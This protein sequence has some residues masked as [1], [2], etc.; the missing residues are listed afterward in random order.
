M[1]RLVT[2]EI[3][4]S[5]LEEIDQ[6]YQGERDRK[7]LILLVAD[8]TEEAISLYCYHIWQK[9]TV[10][11]LNNHHKVEIVSDMIC[12][13]MPDEIYLGED[14]FVKN[15]DHLRNVFSAF[16]EYI[17]KSGYHHYMRYI[18]KNSV[19]DELHPEVALL[20]PTSGSLGGRKTAALSYA[21]LRSNAVSIVRALG[22]QSGERA[23]LMLPISYVYGLS[24]VNSYLLSGGG[25][26]LPPGNMFQK[27]Y[28][29]FLEQNRVNSFCGVPHTYEIMDRLKLFRR[30]WKELHLVTQAGGAMNRSLKEKMLAWIKD[31]KRRG[32]KIHI[33]VM[34][35]QTEATARMSSFFLDEYSYKFDS[36]GKAIPGGTFE[37]LNPDANGEGEILYRGANVFMG[38]VENR[39][40]LLCSSA[41]S[42]HLSGLLHTEDIGKMD[43]DGFLYITGRKKRFI[44][45]NGIRISLDEM[46]RQIEEEMHIRVVCIQKTAEEMLY[47]C[48]LRE[49]IRDN[50]VISALEAYFHYHR[51]AKDQYRICFMDAFCYNENGKID[52]G[53]MQTVSSKIEETPG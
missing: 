20:M 26:L 3:I 13:F 16:H 22:I 12:R 37:I 34:Y 4:H 15:Q 8:N 39:D 50:E 14:Y 2:Q 18:R 9:N 17:L 35:G 11:L 25:L 5:N 30:E 40:D 51:I 32:E 43:E 28:W 6:Q 45:A 19:F 41:I 46:E 48:V 23:A 44:K 38:Y 21:N 47:A 42:A 36:V 27:T 31:R 33:A 24:V 10:L 7:I 49:E 1:N 29:D 52:Y 53:R